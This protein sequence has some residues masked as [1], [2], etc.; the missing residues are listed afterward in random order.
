MGLYPQPCDASHGGWEPGP[1]WQTNAFDGTQCFC[2]CFFM[3]FAVDLMARRGA[4]VHFEDLEHAS[5]R[6]V[7]V[8]A[9]LGHIGYC[10]SN[11]KRN[12]KHVFWWFSTGRYIWHFLWVRY[13]GYSGYGTVG[14][15]GYGTVGTVGTVRWVRWVRYSGYAGYPLYRTQRTHCTVPSVPTVPY[16]PYRTHRTVPTV[17]TVPYHRT[18]RTAPFTVPSF[19]RTV[20]PHRALL[21]KFDKILHF[22]FLETCFLFKVPATSTKTRALSSKLSHGKPRPRLWIAQRQHAFVRLEYQFPDCS[23]SRQRT[24]DGDELRF[25]LFAFWDQTATLQHVAQHVG[26]CSNM[27]PRFSVEFWPFEVSGH[28][29]GIGFR[30]C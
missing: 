25:V 13:G 30:R 3:N 19:L 12:E 26:S 20:P 29:C 7:A 10:L 8:W 14:T 28:A 16:P 6:H 1:P 5:V 4:V 18:Q 22:C 11:F 24:R 17:P 23:R 15:V 9:L 2:F 27:L 21:L